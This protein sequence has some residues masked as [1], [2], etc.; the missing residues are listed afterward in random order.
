MSTSVAF[1]K[2]KAE[3]RAALVGYLPAG[4]PS[5]EGSIEALTTM[6]EAGCDI[7]EIGLPYSDPVMDGPTIQDAVQQALDGGVRV[8]DV[9]RVVEAV[10]ATGVPTLVMTSWN[11]IERR[12]V[13]RFAQQLQDAGGAGLI[14]PD[15]TPD[16]APEWIEAAD[17]RDLDKVFLVA[18]SSTDE[19]IAMT[20]AQCRGFVYATAVMGVT[21]AR[22][23]TSELAAPLVA[24]TRQTTDLPVGVGL[25]VSNG[26][27]AA[28]MA[29]Y[30][31][32]VIVG[33]AF[34]RTL[35]DNRSDEQAA[36]KALAH[37]TEDLA[38]GVRAR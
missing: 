21:G 15:I 1:E 32:G 31:D 9:F 35:L 3:D 24:R 26:A 19:R 30:A 7:I 12:G 8:D 6:V 28:E 27:Q 10:A 22:A 13:D 23:K 18:P 37:L 11:P 33:S 36:L 5:V 16:F 25:G 4:F 38:A 17:A 34:V 2:A 20:T 29:A 14:T